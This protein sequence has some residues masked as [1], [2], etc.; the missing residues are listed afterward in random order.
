MIEQWYHKFLWGC[1]YINAARKEDAYL[2][3]CHTTLK[4]LFAQSS[5]IDVW[6]GPTYDPRIPLLYHALAYIT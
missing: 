2:V 6:Q 5:L 1:W 4:E 3:P